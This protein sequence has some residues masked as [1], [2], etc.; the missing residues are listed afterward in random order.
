LWRFI[1]AGCGDLQNEPNGAWQ[2]APTIRSP[3]PGAAASQA[4]G[5]DKA[6]PILQNEA[7]RLV[8]GMAGRVTKRS[9]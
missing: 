7:I 6:W 1:S 3:D 8:L 4:D 5:G 2:G 9:R